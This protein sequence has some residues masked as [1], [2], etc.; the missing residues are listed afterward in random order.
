MKCESEQ[1]RAPGSGRASRALLAVPEDLE[2]SDPTD[3]AVAQLETGDPV[4]L[5]V[6]EFGR[7]AGVSAERARIQLAA[8]GFVAYLGPSPTQADHTRMAIRR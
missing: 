2:L 8:A 3:E 4:A 1:A 6:Y 5:A 7:R